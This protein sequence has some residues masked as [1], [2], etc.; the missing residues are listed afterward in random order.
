[1]V[2]ILTFLVSFAGRFITTRFLTFLAIKTFIFSLFTIVLPTILIKLMTKFLEYSM[3]Y[4]HSQVTNSGMNPISIDLIGM[5]GYLAT[6][7]GLIQCFSIVLSAV[8][9]RATL[10]LISP[11]L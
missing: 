6:E 11:R 1:M 3:D 8:A 10:N 4:A 9:L 7:T 2:Q 5:G